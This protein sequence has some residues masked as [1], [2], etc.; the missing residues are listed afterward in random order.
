MIPIDSRL[1]CTTSIQFSLLSRTI[2]PLEF[3]F[4]FYLVPTLTY[5]YFKERKGGGAPKLSI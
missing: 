4:S 2:S 3:I 1:K 5:Q